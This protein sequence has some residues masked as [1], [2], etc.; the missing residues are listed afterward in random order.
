GGKSSFTVGQLVYSSNS[1][2]NGSVAEGVQ[3]PYEISTTVGIEITNIS[4]DFIAYP[5]PTSSNIVLSNRDF[6][7]EKLN[8]QL[9][10]MSGKLLKSNKVNAI[11]TTID[12]SELPVSNYVLNINNDSSTIKSFKIIKS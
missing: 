9:Y 7:N 12:M 6:N 5:N 8:Y 4:L 1:G 2:S 10:D 3:Q 11:N